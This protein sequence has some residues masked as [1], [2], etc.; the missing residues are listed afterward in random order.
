VKLAGGE[1][2][3]GESGGGVG[4]SNEGGGGDGGRARTAAAKAVEGSDCE[5]VHSLS[6]FRT[7]INARRKRPYRYVLRPRLGRC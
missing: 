2:G 5:F 1:G 3:G 7:K 4:G 6:I